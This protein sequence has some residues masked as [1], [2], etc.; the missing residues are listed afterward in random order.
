MENAHTTMPYTGETLDV[1]TTLQRLHKAATDHGFT[2]EPLVEQAGTIIP[3]FSKAADRPNP[4]R[5]YISTGMHGDEPAGPL[6]VLDMLEREQFSQ[7]IDWTIFPM[8]NPAGL[9]LNQRENHKGVDLNRDYS[10]PET[11]EVRA[12]VAYIEN[13]EPWDLALML[14]EDWES[15]GF[16]LYD[17]FTDLTE[18]WAKTIIESVGRVCPID[19]ND[20]IDEMSA[21]DGVIS[22]KNI[23]V[24]E[25]PKL[26][27]RFPEA[28]YLHLSGKTGGTYTFEAPSAFDLPT[29]IE[30]LQ[31]AI[32]SSVELMKKHNA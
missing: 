21:S 26:K 3:L 19:L 9:R 10:A 2:C 25:D 4:P 18:D 16:Y 12:H 28:I 8:M 1:N 20:T 6:C 14:H 7:E 17:K 32:S 5:V 30:A 15:D 27:G 22:P 31:T 29:R 23:D 13:S 11:K 24:N